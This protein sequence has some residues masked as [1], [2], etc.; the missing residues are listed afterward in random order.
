MRVWSTPLF[1]LIAGLIMCV[2]GCAILFL[3]KPDTS[4]YV[5]GTATIVEF[6]ED[7]TDSDGNPI[8][9]TM[10]TYEV[11][12][13]T[14]GPNNLGTYSSSQHI[15]DEVKIK[16][17][18]DDPNQLIS[19]EWFYYLFLIIGVVFLAIG[20]IVLINNQ[21]KFKKY[22]DQE[23]QFATN[24]AGFAERAKNVNPLDFTSNAGPIADWNQP[25]VK[26]Y[27]F[28]F[29]KHWK[30]GYYM[31]DQNRQMVYEGK[32][33][34]IT[35]LKPFEFEFINHQMF[36]TPIKHSVGH[37]VTSSTNGSTVYSYVKFDGTDI[38]DMLH[39]KGIRIET[40][41][42]SP[43]AYDY[44]VSLAGAPFASIHTTGSSLHEDEPKNPFS[45]VAVNGRYRIRTY[46]DDTDLVFLVCFAM[47]RC[48]EQLIFD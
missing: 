20:V 28:S 18:P 41:M 2:V 38:W 43:V 19:S 40:N 32:M 27:Y 3:F 17:N 46:S 15:G 26:R 24:D 7:G 4:N 48:S 47:A 33:S 8:Y 45:N 14:Y 42:T 1:F 22:L 6:V 11:G 35:L 39:E 31:E 12:G 23:T 30:Q 44:E 10:V 13:V 5:D 21:K 25:N 9:L 34:K 16:Y 37:T 29:D 36:G